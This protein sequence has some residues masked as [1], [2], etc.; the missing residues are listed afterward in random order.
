MN[1]QEKLLTKNEQSRPGRNLHSIKAVVIHYVGNANQDAENVVRYFEGLKN[2]KD[3]YASAHYVVGISGD[4]IQCLPDDEVAYHVGAK[5]YTNYALQELSAYPNN[6]TIG[7]EMCH[8]KDGFT[9]ET[10]QA[11]AELTAWLLKKYHLTEKDMIRHYDITKKIC[12]KFYV[13]DIRLWNEFKNLVSQ[14]ISEV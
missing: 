10:V 14:K 4:L 7:I 11:T 5:V 9:V 13:E 2:Q 8:I 6:C 3:T 1:I 12:P